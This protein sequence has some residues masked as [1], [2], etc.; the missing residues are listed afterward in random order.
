[1]QGLS[2]SPVFTATK[3]NSAG[4]NIGTATLGG[5]GLTRTL[6]IAEFGV[7]DY[8]VV[9]ANLSGYSDTTTVVRLQN[10]TD[11]TD[12]T[13][14]VSPI[15]GLLTNESVTVAANSS[16]VVTSFAN[17]GGNFKVYQGITDVS[18][19]ATYSVASSSNV[20]IAINSSGVYTVTALSA[21]NG[22][23]TLQAIYG[24]VTIQKIYSISKSLAGPDGSTGAPGSATFVITRSANDGSAP[25]NVEVEGI[26]GRNPVAGDICTVSYND[27]N[28]AVVY[29]YITSWTLFTTYITG[30]LIVENTITSDKLSVN[31][32]SA[33]SADLGSITAGDLSIGLSPAIIGTTMTGIGAHLYS[34]GRFVV[35]NS[36]KNMT[37]DASNLYINGISTATMGGLNTGIQMPSSPSESFPTGY[38]D[39]FVVTKAG[40][41][42]ITL[43]GEIIIGS[44][45]TAYPNV[46]APVTVSLRNISGGTLPGTTTSIADTF[47]FRVVAPIVKPAFGSAVNRLQTPLVWNRV[48]NLPVGTYAVF[49]C[50]DA[51]FNDS[52]GNVGYTVPVNDRQF[53]GRMNVFQAM[54]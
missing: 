17:A 34:N 51:Y 22:S 25:T 20:T 24:T 29:R 30:S 52:G 16:G 54:I 36:T 31:T 11:G 1:L 18:A 19:S 50:S 49:A 41:V 12:G 21:L 10:G 5:S 7:A 53:N 33:I 42:Q 8:C 9:N 48:T 26:L 23:A 32:L 14:G 15:V 38:V 6:T 13:N 45:T 37:F 28:N 39:S 44:N 43:I 47:S 27:Y 46:Y 4:T 2:G 40:Y 3:Y 35:G